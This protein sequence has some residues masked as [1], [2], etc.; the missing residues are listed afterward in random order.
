MSN[1]LIDAMVNMKEQ[2]TLNLA[3]KMLKDGEDP[4]RVLEMGREALEIVGKQFE[5]GTYFLPE[6]ILAGEMLKKISKMAKPFLEPDSE[7]K[8]ES[9]GKIVIGTVEGDVHDIGKDIVTFLL[10]VSGFEVHDLGVDVPAQR[11]VDAIKEEQ[12]EIVG[13]SALLTLAFE[14]LKSTVEAIK[15][16]GLRDQVKI[17]IG[18]GI[19]DEK[20]REYSG[21]DAYG[22]DAVAAVTIAKKWVQNQ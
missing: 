9:P 4:L 2:D 20:V 19:V 6:L 11:F 12:P 13:M 8:T 7:E 3:A 16:A 14:Y 18:G 5:S 1:E 21:A 22:E 10:D 17:M 15:E